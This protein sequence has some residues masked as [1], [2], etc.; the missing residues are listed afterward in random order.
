M[1]RAAV[2]AFEGSAARAWASRS[3][4]QALTA[5]EQGSSAYLQQASATFVAQQQHLCTS[6]FASLQQSVAA[7]EQEE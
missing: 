6:A 5:A 3:L 4:R 7:R 2:Q 1:L